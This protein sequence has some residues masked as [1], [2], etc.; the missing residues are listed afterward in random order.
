MKEPS[1]LENF[2]TIL[3][4]EDEGHNLSFTEEERQIAQEFFQ[5]NNYYNFSIFPKLLPCQRDKYSYTDALESTKL[6]NSCA[7]KSTISPLESRNGSKQVSP[8]TSVTYMKVSNMQRRNAI[9]ILLSITP[10]RP[11]LKRWKAFLRHSIRA[12]N[13]SLSIISSSGMVASLFGSWWKNSPSAKWIPS[14]PY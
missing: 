5:Y 12:R 2:I 6:M 3:S 11:I 8:I 7:E 1:T 4:G 13:H 10:E 14:Y 9:S